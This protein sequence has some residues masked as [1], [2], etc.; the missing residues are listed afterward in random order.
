M[1]PEGELPL[2]VVAQLNGTTITDSQG[3]AVFTEPGTPTVT[4]I[5]TD[6]HGAIASLPLTVNVLNQQPVVEIY[7]S[8]TSIPATAQFFATIIATDPDLRYP[9]RVGCTSLDIQINPA[10]NWTRRG[11]AGNCV[12][13]ATFD[14]PGP[15]TLTIAAADASG[16]PGGS[17][18]ISINVTPAPPNPYPEILEGTF[19]V[20]A[21]EGPARLLC[22]PGERCEAPS[23]VLLSNEEPGE[24]FYKLPIYM[25]LNAVDPGG[26]TPTV[27]WVCETGAFGVP[28]TTNN[29]YGEPSCVPSYSS[30]GPVKVYAIVR[31]SSGQELR[32]EP[33]IYRM[34]QQGPN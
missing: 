21:T 5:A 30:S 32:S 13:W 18:S 28:V 16:G 4:I 27:T 25:Y 11:A 29:P 7:P 19:S 22:I 24:D 2:T 6:K 31:D 14:Q 15:Y 9:S 12:V 20:L 33:R 23:G 1:D 3:Y 10:A 17:R 34:L 26:T 8:T